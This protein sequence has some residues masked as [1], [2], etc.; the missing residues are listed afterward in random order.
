MTRPVR[1]APLLLGLLAAA[2]C[3]SP[4]PV[5]QVSGT[6]VRGGQ[7]VTAGDVNLYMKEKGI[8][9]MAPLDATGRF[10]IPTPLDVGTYDVYITP[11]E[12]PDAG[13]AAVKRG[14]PI[15]QKYRQATTSGL[16]A[17]VKSGPND[18]TIELKD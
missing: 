4:P 6:V 2:G 8:G 9:V 3:S 10:T 18:L 14:P 7:P 17:E 11:P 12:S 13:V 15:P 5:G 16:T 1:L